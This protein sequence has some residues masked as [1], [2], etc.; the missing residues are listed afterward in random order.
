MKQIYSPYPK[1]SI[2]MVL[3]CF[4]DDYDEFIIDKNNGYYERFNGNLG[5]EKQ[6][7]AILTIN[8]HDIIF[9]FRCIDTSPNKDVN[10]RPLIDVEIYMEKHV[11]K[12]VANKLFS[13]DDI[14]KH[15]VEQ[16]KIE[17]IKFH[18]ELKNNFNS[19]IQDYTNFINGR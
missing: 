1:K 14:V 15:L 6:A 4:S 13:Y 8:N 3:F 9:V 19:R 16:F 5:K 18:G 7:S 10:G 2:T 17:N 11:Y 12:G